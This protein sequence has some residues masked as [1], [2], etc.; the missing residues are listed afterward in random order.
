ME[1]TATCPRE[2]HQLAWFGR[3]PWRIKQ[4]AVRAVSWGYANPCCI[5]AIGQIN[6]WKSANWFS[7]LNW[8]IPCRWLWKRSDFEIFWRYFLSESNWTFKSGPLL[9]MLQ[10]VIQIKSMETSESAPWAFRFSNRMDSTKLDWTWF[11]PV[12][13]CCF[14]IL[15]SNVL[16]MGQRWGGVAPT[17]GCPARWKQATGLVFWPDP[18]ERCVTNPC[19]FTRPQT[20]QEK[21]TREAFW[22]LCVLER[23]VQDLLCMFVCIAD[24]TLL[25]S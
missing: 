13:L 23:E 10:S 25:S 15:G 9:Q 14:S 5:N 21:P 6:A 16:L 24:G 2:G 17:N 7:G 1:F 22:G 8:T 19:K 11:P 12:L 18:A 20:R 4:W 3:D